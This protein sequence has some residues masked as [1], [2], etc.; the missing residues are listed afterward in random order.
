MSTPAGAQ[1][2]ADAEEFIKDIYNGYTGT[3]ELPSDGGTMWSDDI[4][5]LM[6]RDDALSK[7]AGE[8][9]IL[10]DD[11]FCKGN[12]EGSN[13]LVV[14]RIKTD[15]LVKGHAYVTVVYV[16]DKRLHKNSFDLVAAR[17]RWYIHDVK[18]T[19]MPS[20]YHALEH[21]IAAREKS[22]PH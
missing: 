2:A 1:N 11:V 12:C 15:R 6:D 22:R 10:S 17:G 14:K 8:N 7:A 16:T 9:S 21:D 4:I 20:L 3:T 18:N 13:G 19:D 5:S